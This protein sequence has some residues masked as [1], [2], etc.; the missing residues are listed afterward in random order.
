MKYFSIIILFIFATYQGWSQGDTTIVI[1]MGDIKLNLTIDQEWIDNNT[2]EKAEEIVINDSDIKIKIDTSAKLRELIRLKNTKRVPEYKR[3]FN[4]KEALEQGRLAAEKKLYEEAINYYFATEAFDPRMRDSVKLKVN[5]AFKEINDLKNDALVK[6]E[7]ANLAL[8]EAKNQTKIAIKE[9]IEADRQ[10]KIAIKQK[11][12]AVEKTRIAEEQRKIAVEKTRIA[13]EQTRIAKEQRKIAEIQSCLAIEQT[14][15][16]EIQRARAERL[17]IEALSKTIALKSSSLKYDNQDT[18]KAFLA[19]EAYNMQKTVND[20]QMDALNVDDFYLTE[21]Q[22]NTCMLILDSLDKEQMAKGEPARISP[23]KLIAQENKGLI[24]PEIYT[25]LNDALIKLKGHA[26]DEVRAEDKDAAGH[27]STVKSIIQT[28][29][30]IFYTLGD[31]R[32]IK[33][34]INDWNNVGKPTFDGIEL[35]QNRRMIDMAIAIVPGSQKSDDLIAIG[36]KYSKLEFINYIGNANS[37]FSFVNSPLL[38]KNRKTWVKN[39]NYNFQQYTSRDLDGIFD[40]ALDGKKL[41]LMS[42]LGRIQV[43]N[44]TDGKIE[45]VKKLYNKKEDDKKRAEQIAVSGNDRLMAVGYK[46]GRVDVFDL[47]DF[48]SVKYDLSFLKDTLKG[49]ITELAINENNGELAVGTSEGYVAILPKTD[50]GYSSDNIMIREA[51][52]LQISAID[53]HEVENEK[54]EMVSIMA[55]GSHD[56]T[57]SIW[58]MEEFN[59]SLYEPFVFDDKSTLVTSLE[60]IKTPNLKSHNQIV[61][62]YFDGT[63]KFWTLEIERLANEL[64]CTAT[65]ELN[66]RT[67]LNEHEKE[68]Y[69]TE[70]GLEIKDYTQCGDEN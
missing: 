14:K 70:V 65:S 36:G 64:R 59:N 62:G 66:G 60:F 57:A 30:K 19:L 9:K 27:I 40:M 52:A 68:K 1:Q 48:K 43:M 18:V 44:T 45:T 46:D 69:R 47:D 49:S 7:V 29:P 37:G 2:V 4:D 50:N 17:R 32:L 54:G 12:I 3:T 53:F 31:G 6:E 21:T 58:R 15:I 10:R 51:H 23:E 34:D 33:W 8:V 28:Q 56:K 35:I 24:S 39:P 20:N 38:R 41:Y 13:V 55:I 63:V 61:I 22:K 26:Y 5:E 11:R 25:G 42:K 67:E 16:A